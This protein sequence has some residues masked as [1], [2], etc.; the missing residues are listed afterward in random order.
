M[1]Y[2]NKIQ[3]K[4]GKYKN[5]EGFR[6]WDKPDCTQSQKMLDDFNNRISGRNTAIDC[7]GGDGRVTKAVLCP[8]FGEVDLVE[9][10]NLIDDAQKIVPEIKNFYKSSLQNFE[11]TRN[12][13]CV[14][15]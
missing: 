4:G 15:V 10:S 14:W 2:W 3:R 1:E 13:D 7:G 6:G 11:F 5:L 9:P 8:N 12:Y